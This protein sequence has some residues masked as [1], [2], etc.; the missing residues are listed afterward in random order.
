MSLGNMEKELEKCMD[1]YPP[2]FEGAMTLLQNGADI[3]AT[4]DFERETLLSDIIMYYDDINPCKHCT[5]KD[6]SDCADH[7]NEYDNHYLPEIVRFFLE[8]GYDVTFGNG[9]HGGESLYALCF[10]THDKYILDAAKILLDAG[11]DPLYVT[12]TVPEDQNVMDAISWKYSGCLPVYGDLEQECL[13][14]VLSY[15]VKAKTEGRPYSEIHWHDVAIGKR[16]DRVYS[17][18]PSNL[19]AVF[20]FA[21]GE[22]L[23]TDCFKE[24]IVLECEGIPLI[25]THFC[26]AFV[27]PYIVPEHP[28]DLSHHL[29]SLIG[30]QI[31]EITFSLNGRQSLLHVTMDDGSALVIC[32][33][34]NYRRNEDYCA[35]FYLT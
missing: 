11:A 34:A 35:R 5:S 2:D 1:Q 23:Y 15:I 20:N 14:R 10:S 25:L 3:N 12:D 4:T 6:C 28:Q 9:A 22:H 33:N 18:A 30:K 19:D 16:I 17:C 8:S 24:P 27:N 32:D 21:T 29:G 7:D 26:H 31:K 13:F